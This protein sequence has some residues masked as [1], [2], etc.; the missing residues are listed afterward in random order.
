MIVKTKL[1]NRFKDTLKCT[2]TKC[3][4]NNQGKQGT[5]ALFKTTFQ[6]EKYLSFIKDADVRKCFMSFRI[7]TH[8]LEIERGRYKNID[9]KNRF[10][11]QCHSEAVEDEKHFV[12]NCNLYGSLRQQF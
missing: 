12:F 5:Y 9:A 6:K 8:T 4:E 3:K 1:I 11:K 10:C 7:S 2:L